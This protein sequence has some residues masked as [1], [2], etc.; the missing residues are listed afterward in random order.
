MT[1]FDSLHMSIQEIDSYEN[2]IEKYAQYR[3]CF[4]VIETMLMV[5]E[6]DSDDFQQYSQLIRDK[7]DALSYVME[8]RGIK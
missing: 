3:Y 2:S 4:G 5:G 1:P 8:L 6:V 7:F